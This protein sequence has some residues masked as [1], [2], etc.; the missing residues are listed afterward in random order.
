[1]QCVSERECVRFT[2]PD[3]PICW[4]PLKTLSAGH[5]VPGDRNRKKT[6]IAVLLINYYIEAYSTARRSGASDAT[7]LK[8]MV[9]AGA[10]CHTGCSA[11]RRVPPLLK[12]N[13][14]G[15]CHQDP[16]ASRVGRTTMEQKERRL[17]PHR[18]TSL[19]LFTNCLYRQTHRGIACSW[20]PT[21]ISLSSLS[22]EIWQRFLL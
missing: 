13:V 21:A 15:Y 2:L 14:Q 4:T 1:M 18:R 17:R 3:P 5:R 8:R 10:Y 9:V 11:G 16:R 20:H 7:D 22:F 6:L 12:H 19:Q